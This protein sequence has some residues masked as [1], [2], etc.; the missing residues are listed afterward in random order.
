M[1]GGGLRDIFS[2]GVFDWPF[3]TTEKA[4]VR[5]KLYTD[6][7]ITFRLDCGKSCFKR[8]LLTDKLYVSARVNSWVHH[9]SNFTV[10][11]KRVKL[12]L[13]L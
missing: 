12:V 3:N 11:A 1:R 2:H 9:Y 8:G 7:T 4:F 5:A 6:L 13:L 10:F